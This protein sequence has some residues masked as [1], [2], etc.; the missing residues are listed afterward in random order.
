M[1]VL[2][3]ESDNYAVMLHEYEGSRLVAVVNFEEESRIEFPVEALSADA[4]GCPKFEQI[5]TNYAVRSSANGT[6]APFEAAVYR[7]L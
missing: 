2:S 7:L 6:Y 1:T 5:L 4:D 3:K